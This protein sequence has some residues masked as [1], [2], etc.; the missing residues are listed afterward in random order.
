MTLTGVRRLT[1]DDL[2][3]LLAVQAV[4]LP[5]TMSARFGPRF[6]ALYHRAML[7]EEL[8]YCDGYFSDGQLVGYLSYTADTFQLLRVTFRR[9][10][11]AFVATLAGS[12]VTQPR[13]A[14]LLLRIVRLMWVRRPEPAQEIGAELLSIG[15]LPDFRG[16]MP[17]GE[18]R[19][20][21][22][23]VLLEPRR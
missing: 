12:L 19:E 6:N 11:A 15:V 22:G 20:S 2:E 5:D 16:R 14:A 9:H 3:R 7:R 23:G 13:R 17:S 18:K 1:I 10:A 21:A 4:T 8:Y